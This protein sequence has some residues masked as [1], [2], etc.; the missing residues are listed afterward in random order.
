MLSSYI[1][2]SEEA[3][4]EFPVFILSRSHDLDQVVV[5]LDGNQTRA[6]PDH[7]LINAL[8]CPKTPALTGSGG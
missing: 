7:H 6:F 8:K 2:T 3:A 4:S 5:I 1:R